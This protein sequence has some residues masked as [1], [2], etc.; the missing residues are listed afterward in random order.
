MTYVEAQEQLPVRGAP[1]ILYPITTYV[2]AGP[3]KVK[4]GLILMLVFIEPA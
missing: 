3:V 4:L 1:A 2:D